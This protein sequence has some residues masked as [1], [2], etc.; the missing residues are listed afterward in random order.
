MALSSAIANQP[1]SDRKDDCAKLRIIAINAL[2]N[3][4][5]GSGVTISEV[6]AA[7]EIVGCLNPR[8]PSRNDES[9][10]TLFLFEG[11]LNDVKFHSGLLALFA[12]A[13]RSP[14]DECAVL[15]RRRLGAT[16]HD[17]SC[18][19][20]AKLSSKT[21]EVREAAHLVDW[22][23]RTAR[24]L[25]ASG[26]LTCFCALL[27]SAMETAR[28]AQ[29]ASD[30]RGRTSALASALAL[31]SEAVLL[32]SALSHS[33]QAAP[34]GRLATVENEL[35]NS[36]FLDHLALLAQQLSHFSE[37]RQQLAT[38]MHRMGLALKKLYEAMVSNG[39]NNP[40]RSQIIA[41]AHSC[42][43]Y[44][45]CSH[46]VL[47]CTALDGERISYGLPQ[48]LGEPEAW[49]EAMDTAAVSAWSWA[50]SYTLA[51][52]TLPLFTYDGKLS[53]HEVTW[54]SSLQHQL[55]SPPRPPPQPSDTTSCQERDD[56]KAEAEEPA[57]PLTPIQSAGRH[58][59][60]KRGQVGENSQSLCQKQG[61]GQ[62]QDAQGIEPDRADPNHVE[63]EHAGPRERCGR[64]YPGL[65]Q[66][67]EV[68]VQRMDASPNA[69][70]A[71]AQ[72]AQ[73]GAP[74]SLTEVLSARLAVAALTS[75]I[76]TSVLNPM[77]GSKMRDWASTLRRLSSFQDPSK[78]SPQ[79][80]IDPVANATGSAAY[81]GD[82][83]VDPQL[84]VSHFA[85]RD[86]M[87]R[88]LAIMSNV[89]L[90]ER[91]TLLVREH[92][93]DLRE[94]MS[95]TRVR[96]VEM[97]LQVATSSPPPKPH[98]RGRLPISHTM[99]KLD[100]MELEWEQNTKQLK[101]HV[102]ELEEQEVIHPA[103]LACLRP[104]LWLHVPP[105]AWKP[106][107]ALC[108]RLSRASLVSWT[109][110]NVTPVVTPVPAATSS[111]APEPVQVS[112]VTRSSEAMAVNTSN[113]T[114]NERSPAVATTAAAPAAAPGT[115]TTAASA[116]GHDCQVLQAAEEA[117]P[118]AVRISASPPIPSTPTAASLSGEAIMSTA[119][120]GTAV[121][122][123]PSAQVVSRRRPPRAVLAA[124]EAPIVVFVSLL[125]SITVLL[126]AVSDLCVHVPLQSPLLAPQPLEPAIDL[127]TAVTAVLPPLPKVSQHRPGGG[128]VYHQ[129]PSCLMWGLV[130]WWAALLQAAELAAA[131]A[132]APQPPAATGRRDFTPGF[133]DWMADKSAV[134][135]AQSLVSM[136]GT[137]LVTS[138]NKLG[139]GD[140]RGTGGAD[141]AGDDTGKGFPV[142][143]STAAEEPAAAGR[144]AT[145]A[146]GG[147]NVMAWSAAEDG[148]QYSATCDNESAMPCGPLPFEAAALSAGWL[149]AV[150]RMLL[151][152]AGPTLSWRW[153]RRLPPSTDMHGGAAPDVPG[154]NPSIGGVVSDAAAAPLATT[155]APAAAA[156]SAPSAS[157]GLIWLRV[158]LSHSWPNLRVT[159]AEWSYTWGQFLAYASDPRDVTELVEAAR[160]LLLLS[161]ADFSAA[162][163]EVGGSAYRCN[164]SGKSAVAATV[165]MAPAGTA[166]VGAD[167]H[168]ADGLEWEACQ[169]VG[170]QLPK[171]TGDEVRE[172]L[173]AA[174]AVVARLVTPLPLDWLFMDGQ[175]TEEGRGGGHGAPG[176]GLRLQQRQEE[177]VKE[178]ALLQGVR[179]LCT[180][181]CGIQRPRL[182][183]V[184]LQPLP[185]S[186][187]PP[188][189]QQLPLQQ[190]QQ[191]RGLEQEEQQ[192]QLQLTDLDKT[193]RSKRN[194]NE[195][196]SVHDSRK[197]LVR[198]GWNS[199]RHDRE[200]DCLAGGGGI[201]AGRHSETHHEGIAGDL[202][203]YLPID[204]RHEDCSRGFR[205]HRDCSRGMSGVGGGGGGGE[206]CEST[207]DGRRG[208]AGGD[209]GICGPASKVKG[210]STGNATTGASTGAIPA[211]GPEGMGP[212]SSQAAQ[213]QLKESILHI[214][215]RLLPTF[216]EA[217]YLLPYDA[218]A[219]Q[220]HVTAEAE[221]EV[222]GGG[223]FPGE[224]FFVAASTVLAW[225]RR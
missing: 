3:T 93:K 22:T 102:R 122:F 191:Q 173:E 189:L 51:A 25:T 82:S 133:N 210:G 117:R 177:K 170:S 123:L 20:A 62:S 199:T 96:M 114:I 154:Q 111:R 99:W 207:C 85:K 112:A 64:L 100:Q 138:R 12:L 28:A 4:I 174:V 75:W 109:G 165:A 42:L 147:P 6:R 36:P 175:E 26:T 37:A 65:P 129:V 55:Q 45:L 30:S 101:N 136:V 61:L 196:Q 120:V 90:A 218:A 59:K 32:L 95:K 103:M 92:L 27:R 46:V 124:V 156:G 187:P 152:A 44:L 222:Q 195:D 19:A 94:Q 47:L 190:K 149:R 52:G 1:T 176:P 49:H 198:D 70:S 223:W 115:V 167:R 54:G 104:F 84:H 57:L 67:L 168:T 50:P 146:A 18:I 66:D 63:P 204:T 143:A 126:Q 130:E 5:N 157:P 194:E 148:S 23:A 197:V 91:G 35:D 185:S 192:Q 219:V 24:A 182:A 150:R 116:T 88:A 141:A 43:N 77:K 86:V 72:S 17:L 97:K 80:G 158:P 74:E 225:L 134:N 79:G 155:S 110:E 216:T 181:Y 206:A 142:D 89:G 205:A 113:S 76:R 224:L 29:T 140:L 39:A 106:T 179:S 193:E 48:L 40:N 108:M 214:M 9:D 132:V 164:C 217:L 172:R 171:Q 180:Q 98:S 127:G 163:A 21:E 14:G 56:Q 178:E 107:H 161:M 153:Q 202:C 71:R 121:T 60:I 16:F 11:I 162:A 139:D 31:L 186:F 68:K 128:F 2:T 200:E 188:P 10:G 7:A 73:E 145:G 169:C 166:A 125:C 215:E 184:L 83:A 203:G 183:S 105:F 13:V 135:A 159:W 33:I 15:L 221:A 220:V 69:T 119:T 209:T 160:E 208:D 151:A 137:S 201:G 58:R 213:F 38:H 81:A 8:G 78:P 211:V 212:H 53:R 34:P 87:L 41:P 144:A 118:G 131:A